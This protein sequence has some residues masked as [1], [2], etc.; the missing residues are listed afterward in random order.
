MAYDHGKQE[1]VLTGTGAV[2]A[3]LQNFNL[4]TAGRKANWAPAL[5]PYFIRG[6]AIQGL[7]TGAPVT[8]PVIKL[9]MA[10][11]GTTATTGTTV[12][13]ITLV[14]TALK[15]KV[16]FDDALNQ[17]VSPGDWVQLQ[18]TTAA[19]AAGVVHTARAVLYVEPSWERPVNN[20]RMTDKGT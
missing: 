9:L 5:N 6:W 7:T 18:V 17:K 12:G 16:F 15:G 20:T 3:T 1:I 8:K 13:T 19:S 10:T 11:G 14:S 4:N 2:G